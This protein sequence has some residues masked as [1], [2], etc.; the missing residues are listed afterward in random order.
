MQIRNSKFEIDAFYSRLIVQIREEVR[1]GSGK[2]GQTF[3][4]DSP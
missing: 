4:S 2:N 1:T 3:I